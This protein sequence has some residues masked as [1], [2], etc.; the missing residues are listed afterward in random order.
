MF[1]WWLPLVPMGIIAAVALW[2]LRRLFIVQDALELKTRQLAAM[3]H[4]SRK[5]EQVLRDEIEFWRGAA[6]FEGMQ[7]APTRILRTGDEK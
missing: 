3:Q 6:R 7:G 5:A 1:P 4:S 2:A